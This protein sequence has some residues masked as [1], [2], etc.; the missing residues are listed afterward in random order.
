MIKYLNYIKTVAIRL[1]ER[2]YSNLVDISIVLSPA[3]VIL[4][5]IA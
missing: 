1:E 3:G 4:K 5:F 2:D